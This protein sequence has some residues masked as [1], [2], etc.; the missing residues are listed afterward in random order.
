MPLYCFVLAL[1]VSM[2]FR[3]PSTSAYIPAFPTN[4]TTA[5]QNATKPAKYHVQWYPEGFVVSQSIQVDRRV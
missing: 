5:L 3:D 1:L 2:M 4:D